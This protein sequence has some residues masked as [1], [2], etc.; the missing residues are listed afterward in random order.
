MDLADRSSAWSPAR[1]GA[2]CS[3]SRRTTRPPRW[4]CG[5]RL[6]AAGF[7][8]DLVAAA[9]TQ[10]RLRARAVG[11]FGDVRRRH[12]LHRRRAR[13]GH[14]AGGRRPARAAVPR[15]RRPARA[16][17]SAAA[18]APTRW[19][20]PG[21]T[22]QVTGGRR[23]R[24]DRGGRRGEPAA[25]ARR[26][27]GRRAR[28]GPAPADR[29]GG[30]AH[31]RLARPGAPPPRASR[32]PAGGPAGSS[33]SMRS[34]R[35]GRTVQGIARD[36]PATGA[37]LSPSFPHAA[38]PPGVEAQ[39]TSYAG[40]VARVRAVVGARWPSGPGAAP[41]SCGPAARRADRQRGRRRGGAG[42]R[43]VGLD[44]GAGLAV[45]AGP[46]GDPGR[47]D[48]GADGRDRRGRAGPRASATS[49]P[50]GRSTCPGRAATP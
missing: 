7:D 22:S 13:A 31:R 15:R 17:T 32:T 26:A 3:R 2:C 49:P 44:A 35:R 10:S 4:R 8:A 42:R 14:P 38:V 24:G 16:S 29:R 46:R 27:H 6:R 9:L 5:S 40:E 20:S 50:T 37:K 33:A 48:R 41:W 28:R 39:W 19:P 21:S 18:S 11:K 47:A 12:A 36:L 45:R 34:R 1:G 23:R 30:T 25:L 43:R